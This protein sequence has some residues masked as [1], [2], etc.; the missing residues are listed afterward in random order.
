MFLCGG[1]LCKFKVVSGFVGLKQNCSSSGYLYKYI[2]Y[3]YLYVLS[4]RLHV[5]LIE[6]GKFSVIQGKNIAESWNDGEQI[7]LNW[8]GLH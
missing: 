7:I 6:N 1:F 5:I 4:Y 2:W 3:I 8:D